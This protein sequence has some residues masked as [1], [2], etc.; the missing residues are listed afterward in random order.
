MTAH[1]RVHYPAPSEAWARRAASRLEAIRERVAA[2]AGYTP[3]ETVDVLVSDPVAAANGEALPFLGWPRMVLWTS[4]PA[5]DSEIGYYRD[6]TELLLVH[7]ET[8]LVHM[9]R[10]SRNPLLRGFARVVPFGPIPLLGAQRW[11]L[12][13]YA[14]L[15][16]GR[17]TGYGRPNSDLRAAILRRW[18]QAGK[19]P[20]YGRLSGDPKDWHGMSMPY[21]VGSAYL[22]WLEERAGPGSLRKLWARMT[23]RERRSFEEAFR[24]VFDGTPESLYDRFRAELTYRAMEVEK[25]VRELGPLPRREGELWQDVTW[26]RG[27]PALSPDGKR[28]ALVLRHRDRPAELAVWSTAPDEEAEKNWRQDRDKLLKLDPQDVP[29]VRTRPLP[30]KRLYELP[31]SHGVEPAMPRFMPD[32]RSLLLVRFEPDARGFL[33]PDLFRWTPEGGRVER[34]TRE[35]DLRDPDPAPD[36]GWAVATRDRNGFSQLVKVDLATGAVEDLTAPSLEVVYDRPRIS[37]DGRS[38][39]FARHGEGAWKLGILP[40][41]ATPASRPRAVP[42][43]LSSP[44]GAAAAGQEIDIAPPWSGTVASPAWSPDGRTLYAV[45]GH[46]GFIDVYAFTLHAEGAQPPPLPLTRTLGAA[47]APAPTPDGSGLFYLSLE[48]DGLAVRRVDLRQARAP[49]PLPEGPADLVPA[50]RLAPSAPSDQ[51]TAPFAVADLP[52]P[53]RY[54]AG[55]QELQPLVGGGASSSSRAL[56]LLARGGDVVGRLD[57]LAVGSLAG[58]GAPAGGA[59]AGAWRGWPVTLSFHLFAA[60]ELPSRQDGRLPAAAAGLDLE[61]RGVE[62]GAGWERR[63][64]GAWLRVDSRLLWQRVDPR[65]TASTS[66]GSARSASA[67]GEQLA[68]LVARYAIFRGNGPWRLAPDLGGH[69]ET[70]RTAGGGWSRFGGGLHL[71]V[72]H[73]KDHLELSWQRDGSRNLRRAFDLYELG[74]W[75]GSVVPETALANRI[76]MPALPQGALLGSQHEGERVELR[77]GF[78]PVPLFYERHR[79]WQDGLSRLS[80]GGGGRGVAGVAGASGAARSAWLSAAGLEL[81]WSSAVSP[82]AR[83]PALDLRLGIARLFDDPLRNQTR[84]W[85]ITA[86]RP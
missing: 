19:L 82:I 18:A 29:A 63:P 67:A 16:E 53:R 80:A 71:A 48:P 46:Q 47:L 44:P 17:L 7:E 1:F 84:W 74:G 64:S 12:E 35:A 75:A 81:R 20:S 56:E 83:L 23:A 15:V 3:P 32:G 86:W 51:A 5:A 59:L 9:L 30:R 77:L 14:T 76:L 8:H 72:G 85:L 68:S 43:P 11:L 22:E 21:L 6:W 73:D 57:L 49:L 34:L 61:R 55:R 25:R 78:L 27:A 66:A 40:L 58:G 37:P 41:P 62:L 50:V 39:A 31:A 60:R 70:G 36:G 33:H 4:P 79:L 10:P 54:A 52:D 24:G 65:R 38:V 28:L 42:G 26:S 13:G 2:E 45:V 69:L